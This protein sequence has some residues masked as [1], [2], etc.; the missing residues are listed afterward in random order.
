MINKARV[1]LA[2]LNDRPSE[3]TLHLIDKLASLPEKDVSESFTEACEIVSS[4]S[5][6]YSDKPLVTDILKTISGI[7]EDTLNEYLKM[8]DMLSRDSTITIW[9]D[10]YPICLRQIRQAPAILFLNGSLSKLPGLAVTGTRNCSEYGRKT[11]YEIGRLAARNNITLITGLAKGIDAAATAGALDAGGRT[12]CVLGTHLDK[13]HPMENRPLAARVI[14]KGALISEVTKLAPEHKGMFLRRN[15]IISGLAGLVV[16]V[17]SGSTGGTIGQIEVARSQGRPVTVFDQVTYSDPLYSRGYHK[18]QAQAR[19][20]FTSLDE[21][22]SIIDKYF[23][24]S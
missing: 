20:G 5:L 8:R 16:A 7:G 13:I 24:P 19:S 9:D 4:G 10:A 23:Q 2:L 18:M 3:K 21:L 1:F 22:K 11:A 14:E 6:Y 12:L 17:E 15:R